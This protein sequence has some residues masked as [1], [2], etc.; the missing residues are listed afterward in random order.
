MIEAK[1]LK[2]SVNSLFDGNLSIA[3]V[4]CCSTMR[5]INNSKSSEGLA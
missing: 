4:F 2:S 1:S 3:K 5:N